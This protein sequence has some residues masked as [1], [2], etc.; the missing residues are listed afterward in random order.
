[1]VTAGAAGVAV[2][3]LGLAFT[4]HFFKSAKKTVPWLMLLGGFGVAGVLGSLLARLSGLIV[5]T[6]NSATR[7]LFGAGVPLLAVLIIGTVLVICMRPKGHG[8]NKAT[9]WLALVFPSLV[10]ALG[11]GIAQMM[12]TVPDSVYAAVTQFLAGL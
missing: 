8:P 2:L 7:A 4:L 1:M 10:A 3:F 9:P 11:G 5:G 6:T 12:G